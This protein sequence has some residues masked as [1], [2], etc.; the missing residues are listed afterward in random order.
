MQ[1]FPFDLL[2]Y[3]AYLFSLFHSFVL[4]ISHLHIKLQLNDRQLKNHFTTV[5]I[6][7]TVHV[8]NKHSYPC[9]LPLWRLITSI[10]V[11]KNGLYADK[12]CSVK[13][14]MNVNW[15]GTLTDVEIIDKGYVVFG[16]PGDDMRPY[17]KNPVPFSTRYM[18]RHRLHTIWK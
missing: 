4:N 16:E 7:S 1:K 10:V 11:H 12:S 17:F 15:K 14:E 3:H 13:Q 5:H 9:N 8:S 18:V 2:L 6:H